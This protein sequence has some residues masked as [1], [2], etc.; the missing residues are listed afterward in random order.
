MRAVVGGVCSPWSE[1]T[2]VALPPAPGA[3]PARAKDLSGLPPAYVSTMEFDPLRDE[4]AQYAEKLQAAGVSVTYTNYDGLNHDTFL[5][6]GLVPRG[7][8]NLDEAAAYLRAAF[9]S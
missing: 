5:S 4:G 2:D 6:F 3:A 9:G 8:D 7:R 1:P